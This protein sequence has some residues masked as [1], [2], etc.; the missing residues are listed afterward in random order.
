MAN[1][2]QSVEDLVIW[3]DAMALCQLVYLNLKFCKNFALRD[4]MQRCSISVPSNIAE[5][6]ELNSHRAFIRH[7]Y[8]AKGSC[9]ELR[10]QIQIA[11]QQGYLDHAIYTELL[12]RAK[13]VGARI[14]R[15]IEARRLI[16]KN[17]SMRTSHP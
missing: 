14:Q 7:L 11:R 15:F 5:G 13:L 17:D 4:Q 3:K 6:Y 12:S 1:K 16:E 2:H 8:I 10:T 9:C